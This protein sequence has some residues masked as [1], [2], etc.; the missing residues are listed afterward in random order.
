MMSRGTDRLSNRRPPRSGLMPIALTC[1]LSLAVLPAT[2]LLATDTSE[3][4]S[5]AVDRAAKAIE[6]AFEEMG[7]RQ[8]AYA[9]IDGD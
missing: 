3:L 1:A 2:P 7:V 9:V 4:D 6:R 8:A 5:S